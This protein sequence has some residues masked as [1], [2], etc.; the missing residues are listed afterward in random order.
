MEK[1]C[2]SEALVT[3]CLH[4]AIA[5][6]MPPWGSLSMPSVPPLTNLKVTATA[7]SHILIRLSQS[8]VSYG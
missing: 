3:T 4:G 8:P 2:S 6:N 1:V 7:T 5:Q